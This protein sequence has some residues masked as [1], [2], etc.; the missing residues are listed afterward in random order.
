MFRYFNCLKNVL[1]ISKKKLLHVI[2][3]A[4]VRGGGVDFLFLLV[5]KQGKLD[6]YNGWYSGEKNTAVVL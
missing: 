5:S 2:R 4:F 6:L 3:V 1:K